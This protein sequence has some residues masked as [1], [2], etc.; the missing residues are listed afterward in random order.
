MF[1]HQLVFRYAHTI[2]KGREI[3]ASFVNVESKSNR[4]L[5]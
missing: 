2:W 5:N 4:E 1:R 3:L